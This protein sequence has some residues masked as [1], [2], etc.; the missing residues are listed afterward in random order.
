MKYRKCKRVI[1]FNPNIPDRSFK[2]TLGNIY[3]I[4]NLPCRRFK[5]IQPTRKGFN[6]LD[7]DTSKCIIRQHMYCRKYSGI[8]IPKFEKIFVLKIPNWIGNIKEE[9]V[10][11]IK[12]A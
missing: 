7:V 8:E 9:S 4:S 5:F 6:L 12:T 3:T 1:S 11:N 10:D 2:F